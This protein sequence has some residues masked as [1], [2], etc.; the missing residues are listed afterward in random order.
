MNRFL[1]LAAACAAAVA[2]IATSQ[3]EPSWEL[4][5][6]SDDVSLTLATNGSVTQTISMTLNSAATASGWVSGRVIADASACIEGATSGPVTLSLVVLN[7]DGN[8]SGTAK[9]VPPCPDGG[10][11][12]SSVHLSFDCMGSCTDSARAIFERAGGAGGALQITWHATG[13]VSGYGSD[14][15]PDGAEASIS[16]AP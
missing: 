2:S 5:A 1:S 11:F 13:H 8:G 6:V 10:S 4:S 14:S 7:E 15:V 12:A 9:D 3:I 16:I